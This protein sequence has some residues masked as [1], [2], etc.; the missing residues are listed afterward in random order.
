MSVADD[1]WAL[2]RWRAVV[3][4][5]DDPHPFLT[6]EWQRAW[7][8]H[9]G[10]GELE[11][12]DL[13]D[14][15]V[16]ALQCHGDTLRFLGNRE[17][18]DYPGPAIAPGCEDAAA[19]RLLRALG[20]RR[21]EFENARPQDPFVARLQAAARVERDEPVAILDLPDSWARYLR[22]LSRHSRH[23]LDRKRRHFPAAR[24]IAGDIETFVAFFRDAPG[25]KGTFLTRPIEAFFRAVAPLGRLDALEVD[26]R[27]VAIT[28][29]F[30]TARTY[31]LYNMAFEQS[32]R[33]LSPGIVLLG[34]L[35]ERA[36]EDGLDRFDFMRGLERYKLE[37]GG[38]PQHLIRLS[39]S[40]ATRCGR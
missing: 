20:T 14:A 32:A 5:L 1:G 35:I 23:E 29:G 15:G 27:P 10:A 11:L 38:R 39:L 26:G 40:A 6:P 24:L 19:A 28:L 8:A 7:W 22:G 30:Q 9:F 3:S 36:I 33:A 18:T 21:L 4:L 34:A 2:S 37:L 17:T 16:A 13:G 12:I 31:Y 25:A